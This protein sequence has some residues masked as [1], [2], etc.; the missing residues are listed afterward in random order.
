MKIYANGWER[1]H[2]AISLF[3][4]DFNKVTSKDRIGA[5]EISMQQ[6]EAG[7][8]IFWGKEYVT[9]NGKYMFQ[10]ELSKDDVAKIFVETFSNVN[11]EN[12]I[13]ILNEARQMK[14]TTK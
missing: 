6:T 8:H 5:D 10:L 4:A 11:F 9:L 3:N 13:S 2:G 7:V 1:D 12:I 14:L